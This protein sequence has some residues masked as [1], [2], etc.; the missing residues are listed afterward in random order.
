MS[1]SRPRR[2]DLAFKASGFD[3]AGAVQEWMADAKFEGDGPMLSKEDDKK[4]SMKLWAFRPIVVEIAPSHFTAPS[5]DVSME[6]KF[7]I[8]KGQPTGSLTVKAKKFDEAADALQAA[9]A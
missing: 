6:G 4:V 1:R 3:V 9:R 7:V 5:L 2:F 8:D